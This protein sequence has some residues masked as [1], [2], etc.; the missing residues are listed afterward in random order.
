MSDWYI[1]EDSIDNNHF[2]AELDENDKVIKV[3]ALSK[4][5]C[6]NLDYPESEE[7]GKEYVKNIGL[8]GKWVQTSY[9]KEN[10]SAYVNVIGGVYSKSKQKVIPNQPYP[11]WTYNEQKNRWYAPVSHPDDNNIYIWDE[12]NKC[13]HEDYDVE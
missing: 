3:I 11:S 1:K 7:A 13:W 4:D 8:P 6:K 12:E 9:A 10:N 5:K 2:F